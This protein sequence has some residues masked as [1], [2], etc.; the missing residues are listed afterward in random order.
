MTE[1]QKLSFWPS[2]RLVLILLGEFQML[3]LVSD[4]RLADDYF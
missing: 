2:L 1:I 3:L 4:V